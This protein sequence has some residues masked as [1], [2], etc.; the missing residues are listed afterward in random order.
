MTKET[1][2]LDDR[3]D[4]DALALVALLDVPDVL[5]VPEGQS[6]PAVVD[7]YLLLALAQMAV[8]VQ[9]VVA[10]EEALQIVAQPAQVAVDHLLA[11]DVPIAKK[12]CER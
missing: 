11:E 8:I 6:V 4:Q 5:A 2:R 10:E 7:L 12:L 1:L 3:E 9:T